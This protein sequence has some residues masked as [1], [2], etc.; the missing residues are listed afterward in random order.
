MDVCALVIAW[1]VGVGLLLLLLLGPMDGWMEGEIRSCDALTTGA[2]RAHR[3]AR[4]IIWRDQSNQRTRA[5]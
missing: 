4:A 3:T 1:N 2:V 5:R